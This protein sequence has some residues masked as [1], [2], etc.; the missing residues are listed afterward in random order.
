MNYLGVKI[1]CRQKAN[2]YYCEADLGKMKITAFDRNFCKSYNKII[3]KLK[4]LKKIVDE[5][6]SKNTK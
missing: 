1:D 5:R 3:S 2:G 6:N 4:L